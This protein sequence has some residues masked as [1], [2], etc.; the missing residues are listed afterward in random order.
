MLIISR[1]VDEI[2]TIGY[3]ANPLIQIAV[4]AI[5]G[6]KVRLGITAPKHIEVH[7]K[8]YA[9]KLAEQRAEG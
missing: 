7:R 1:Q 8:E 9:K 6:D 2:I 3:P 4:T 5:R